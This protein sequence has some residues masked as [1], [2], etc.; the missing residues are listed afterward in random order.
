MQFIPR[1]KNQ[2]INMHLVASFRTSARVIQYN[3]N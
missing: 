2:A 3:M 1:K